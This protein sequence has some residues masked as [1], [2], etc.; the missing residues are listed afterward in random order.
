[1][2]RGEFGRS[3]FLIAQGIDIGLY[4]IDADV[5]CCVDSN[6]TTGGRLR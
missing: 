3:H 1:M 6:V 2:V 4:E 5:L